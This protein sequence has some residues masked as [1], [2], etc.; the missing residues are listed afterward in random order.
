MS[1]GLVSVV[2]ETEDNKFCCFFI[3]TGGASVNI[4]L[5]QI[6]VDILAKPIYTAS[7]S[8]TASLDIVFSNLY[9]VVF[10]C[11]SISS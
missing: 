8:I 3:S 9:C 7:A 5:L 6:L 10:S 4:E 1:V 11:C 2:K